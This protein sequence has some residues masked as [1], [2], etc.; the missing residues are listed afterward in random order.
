MSL[1]EER[2]ATNHFV[3]R[4]PMM[5]GYPAAHSLAC[6]K[7]SFGRRCQRLAQKADRCR[8]QFAD[9]DFRFFVQADVEVNN[10]YM[11]HYSQVFKPT[12]IQMML[13]AFSNMETIHIA[14]YSH[15]LDTS[16][17]PKL[18]MRPS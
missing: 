4:G 17:C 12:E 10:C 18:N 3:I 2:I 9:A 13:A 6:R 1:L 15:L 5:R 7:K 8:A 14:A 16:A 11:K